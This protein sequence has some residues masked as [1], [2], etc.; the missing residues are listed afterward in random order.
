MHVSP[1]STTHEGAALDAGKY[2]GT[3]AVAR[4]AGAV[5]LTL[6]DY[7]PRA[8]VPS[9]THTRPYFCYVSAGDFREVGV[10]GSYVASRGTLVF[11]PATET[12]SDEFGASGG[13]CFNIEIAEDLDLT[14]EA[15]VVRGRAVRYA[16]ELYREMR[17]WDA[18]SA[19][20]AEGLTRALVA[21]V[22]F[23]E[24]VARNARPA[25]RASID[26]SRAMER[27]RADPCNPPSLS[28][29]AM[30]A[31]LDALAFARSFRKQFGCGVGAFVRAERVEL[32]KRA[33]ADSARTVSAIAAEL[34]FADQAHLTRVFRDATGWTPAAFRRA[35]VQ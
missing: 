12:H 24:S 21:R 26:L 29:L 16:A 6:S 22:I 4:S 8:T 25:R 5:M 27:L 31:G 20:V 18:A 23:D 13:R 15:G 30:D 9:H 28:S 34:G 19:V 33:L 35:M 1:D 2:F 17:A 10:G 3:P 32:A 14:R 11:H 7:A